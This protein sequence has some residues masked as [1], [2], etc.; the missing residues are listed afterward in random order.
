MNFIFFFI[1]LNIFVPRSTVVLYFS[2]LF[3]VCVQTLYCIPLLQ[4]LW[5][6]G[7]GGVTGSGDYTRSIGCLASCS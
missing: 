1:S 6:G 2:F 5:C 4:L 7:D 3:H